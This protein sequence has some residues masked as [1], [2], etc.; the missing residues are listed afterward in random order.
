MQELRQL[1]IRAR[2]SG[3]DITEAD[4]AYIKEKVEQLKER[5]EPKKNDD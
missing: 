3:K 5:F 2:Y 1:Y 4:V